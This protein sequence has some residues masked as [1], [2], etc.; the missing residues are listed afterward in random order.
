M[1][2]D[3]RM[4]EIQINYYITCAAAKENSLV[5]ANKGKKKKSLLLVLSTSTSTWVG[6]VV[7]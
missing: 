4:S 3:S 6:L 5:G 7:E 1:S 2:I